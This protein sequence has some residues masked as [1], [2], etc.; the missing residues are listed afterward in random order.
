M[1]NCFS[2]LAGGGDV[3]SVRSRTSSIQSAPEMCPSQNTEHNVTAQ[4]QHLYNSAAEHYSSRNMRHVTVN[5]NPHE[6]A[7]FSLPYPGKNKMV[8]SHETT[9]VMGK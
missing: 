9:N 2:G 8:T 1:V 6:L 7:S 3:P 5:H 4:E